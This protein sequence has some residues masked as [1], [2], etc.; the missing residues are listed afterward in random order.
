MIHLVEPYMPV[1]LRILAMGEESLR[2][3]EVKIVLGARHRDIEQASLLL[4]LG[5]RPGAEVGGNAAIDDIEHE[6]GLPFLALGGMDV[7]RIR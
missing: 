3:N 2:N 5:G 7:E 4:D 6:D 1:A